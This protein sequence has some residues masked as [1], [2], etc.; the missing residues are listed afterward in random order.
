MVTAL[1]FIDMAYR[2]LAFFPHVLSMAV[3]VSTAVVAAGVATLAVVVVIAMYIRVIG[4]GAVQK[5][6]HS[7]IGIAADT[8]EQTDTGLGQCH[9]GT[10][11]DA[12]ANQGVN[13]VL[14]QKAGQCTVTAA[15]GAN[16]LCVQ[17]AAVTDFVNFELL[18]VAEMLKNLAVLIGNCNFHGESSFCMDG[19]GVGF[20][21]RYAKVVETNGA[22]L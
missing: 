22:N 15:V 10:T 16:N 21:A 3:V 18:C 12:A 2:L 13:A 7:G 19:A 8:A 1:L 5:G 9:L 4:Q 6:L 17:D 20:P 14:H 11:A